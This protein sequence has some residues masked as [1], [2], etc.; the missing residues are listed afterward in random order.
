MILRVV[1]DGDEYD[2]DIALAIR[3][4]VDNG[5]NV[6]NM[7]FGKD[8]SPQKSFV[9]DA[10]MYADT[11]NVL[12]V[13]ASGNSGENIDIK[14]RYPTDKLINGEHTKCMLNVG[15]TSKELGLNLT[16]I[17]SNYGKIYV[18]LFAPG[19]NIIS[20]APESKY[21]MA[22]GTSFSSPVAS[23]VAALVWSYYP[24]LT[25]LELKDILMNSTQKYKKTKVYYPGRGVKKRKKTKLSNISVT[26]GIINAYNALKLADDFVKNKAVN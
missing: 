17:F 20:L 22:N 8:F 23:G 19:V 13:H 24:E 5:A 10:Y 12:L 2:K 25:A 11:K 9:D 1:P 16:G 18:D 15:A 6:I 7:S 26:G 3:Y 4:A 21:S 14:E